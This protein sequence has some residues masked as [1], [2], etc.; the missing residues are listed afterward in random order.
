M[1]IGNMWED[2]AQKLSAITRS[3]FVFLLTGVI[4]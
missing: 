2:I 3:A 1:F 4:I